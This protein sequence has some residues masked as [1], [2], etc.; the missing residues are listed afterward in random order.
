M[1]KRIE[2]LKVVTDDVIQDAKN[3]AGKEFNGK[4]VGEYFGYHGVAIVALANII[5]S[6][7]KDKEKYESICK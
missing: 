3:F 1:D 5:E 6:L 4:N 7:L 2:A